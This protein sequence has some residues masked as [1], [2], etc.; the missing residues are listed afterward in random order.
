M[1]VHEKVINSYV[2]TRQ[3]KPEDGEMVTYERLVLVFDVNGQAKAIEAKVDKYADLILT[4]AKTPSDSKLSPD[5]KP[6]AQNT[7]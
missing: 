7:T 6:S 1:K 4:V 5:V 3:F 2:E